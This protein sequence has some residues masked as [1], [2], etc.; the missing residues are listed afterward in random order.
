MMNSM[1]ASSR[2]AMGYPSVPA[3][4]S[5]SAASRR[6][7]SLQRQH[8]SMDGLGVLEAYKD[9]FDYD[10]MQPLGPSGKTFHQPSYLPLEIS[11]SQHQ[12][13][14]QP[15]YNTSLSAL[16]NPIPT[17]NAF[18]QHNNRQIVVEASKA[19]AI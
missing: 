17:Q 7:P 14:H 10:L 6:A 5:I 8:R 19:N 18:W 9:S 11:T 16:S 12:H 13:P 4:V 3:N 1:N 15:P 2:N